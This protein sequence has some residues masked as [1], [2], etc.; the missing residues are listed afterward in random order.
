MLQG[1]LRN[2]HYCRDL[3]HVRKEAEGRQLEAGF[4]WTGCDCTHGEPYMGA[5]CDLPRTDD[6][7]YVSWVVDRVCRDDLQRH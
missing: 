6:L 7:R 3:V 5:H 1:L 4:S 2:I